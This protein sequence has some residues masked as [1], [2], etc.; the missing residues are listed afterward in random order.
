MKIALAIIAVLINFIGYFP[1]IRDVLNGKTRPHAYSWLVWAY[2]TLIIFALQLAAHGGAGAFVT[3]GAGSTSF[4]V[5]GL[6]LR[7][8]KQDIT[9]SDTFFFIAALIAT[10]IWIL[11]KA[12][13]LSVSFLVLIDMLGFVPTIR[14][15]WNKPHSETLIMY[16][17]G[18]LRHALSLFALGTI[19]F[20]TVL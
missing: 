5:F 18:A 1:Y 10:A 12:P 16:E 20:I 11:A 6:A 9:L 4:I 17:L 7:Q 3:L 19:S 14:K 8:G 2:I 13:L 15:S